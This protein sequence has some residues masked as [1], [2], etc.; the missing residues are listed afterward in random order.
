MVIYEGPSVIDGAPVVAIATTGSTN[1]KTGGM[2]QTW[3][4][5]ADVDPITAAR[6]GA[7]VSVCGQ[8]VH[9]RAHLGTCYVVLMQGPLAVWRRYKAGGYEAYAPGW[10]RRRRVRFGSYGDPAAVPIEAWRPVLDECNRA[11]STGYTHQWRTDAWR[12]ELAEFCMVSVETASQAR[13]ATAEGLRTYRVRTWSDPELLPGEIVCRESSEGLQ[14]D[15]CGE[16]NGRRGSVVIKPHGQR[17]SK[18]IARVA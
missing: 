8:C 12:A 13:R 4:M 17:K 5:R 3:I 11:E 1:R 7:D 10:L 14:C 6:S 9:R 16:C 15:S 2:V 18:L